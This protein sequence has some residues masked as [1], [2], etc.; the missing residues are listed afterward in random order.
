VALV[1]DVRAAA[2][3]PSRN[4]DGQSAP[5]TVRYLN[6]D[7]EFDS[8]DV[9]RLVGRLR[10]IGL[11]IPVTLEGKVSGTV[12][13][14]VPWNALRT[15][16][17][18]RL[19]GSLTSERFVVNDFAVTAATIRLN[20]R[21]GS[22]FLD[23]FTLSVPKPGAAAGAGAGAVNG[24]AQMQLVPRGQLSASLQVRDL[25]MAAVLRSFDALQPVDGLLSGELV[26]R[27]AVDELRDLAAWR[28]EG[29]I[30][31]R[32]FTL[33]NLPAAAADVRF[34]LEQAVLTAR[35]F[36]LRVGGVTLQSDARLN[37]TGRLAWSLDARASADDAA[38]VFELLKPALHNQ[39]VDDVS[40][41]IRTGPINATAR[42]SGTMSPLTWSIGGHA[43]SSA[44][45]VDAFDGA[46]KQAPI[47]PLV[48]D[49]IDFDYRLDGTML[50]LSQ[51]A[52]DLGGGV[53][54][55]SI[56]VPLRVGQY[57]AQLEWRDVRVTSLLDAPF[58]GNGVANGR[59][60][61][62]AS[63]A[64]IADPA[65]WQLALTTTVDE[66]T[67]QNWSLARL[68]TGE[69]K[70]AD[71]RLTVPGFSALVDNRAI[72]VSLDAQLA[73]PWD[74]SMSF[75]VPELPIAW[76]AKIP[77]I[78]NYIQRP[79][80]YVNVAGRLSGAWKPLRLRGGGRVTGRAVQLDGVTVDALQFGFEMTPEAAKIVDLLAQI[81]GGRVTGAATMA[82]GEKP[83]LATTLGWA[84]VDVAAVTRQLDA[85]PAI[86]S[87]TTTGTLALDIPPGAMGE[88]DKWTATASVQLP[89]F[90][91]YGWQ[92]RHIQ[93]VE[94]RLRAG[95]LK[96]PRLA[97]Q[98]DGQP[99]AASLSLGVSSPW[100]FAGK[101]DAPGLWLERLTSVP[102]LSWLRDRLGGRAQVRGTFEGQVRPV[103]LTA[104]ASVVGEAI[105][106]DQLKIDKLSLRA[107]L[108]PNELR[109]SDVD[110]GLLGGS[111]QGSATIPLTSEGP[112]S[113]QIQWNAVDLGQGLAALGRSMRQLHGVSNGSAAVS[114]PAGRRDD[115]ARWEIDAR[116]GLPDLSAGRLN[117]ASLEAELHQ[118][119]G[120]LNYKAQGR[121]LSG[122]LRLVGSRMQAT[123]E[124]LLEYLGTFQLTLAHASVGAAVQVAQQSYLEPPPVA[125]D[126][127][128]RLASTSTPAGRG[129]QGD[130]TADA[131]QSHGAELAS[132]VQARFGGSA[133]EF[134]VQSVTGRVAGGRLSGAGQWGFDPRQPRAF[135]VSL[136][137]ARLEQL[138]SLET[139]PADAP[140]SGAADIDLRIHP[141][142]TWRIDGAVTSGRGAVYGLPY[143]NARVPLNVRWTPS[144]GRSSLR[145]NSSAVSLSRGRIAGQFTATKSATWTLNGNYRIFRVDIA[146]LEKSLGSQSAHGRGRLSGTL[147]ISGRNVRSVNDVQATLQADLEDTQ[148]NA[149]PLLDKFSR[150]VG[151]FAAASSAFGDGRVEAHLARGVVHVDRLS[152]ASDRMQ[153][154]VTGRIDLVGRLN[155]EATVATGKSINPALAQR[156]LTRLAIVP[157]APASLL[158]QINDI[159]S[160]RVVHLQITGTLTRP[161]IRLRAFATLREE[162]L[163]F[164]LR[165]LGAGAVAP[166]VDR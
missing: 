81:G 54:S 114:I 19:G 160:D 82:L 101:V 33:R 69:V 68:R 89:Q 18:W 86:F 6:T 117:V 55:G 31:L 84:G 99:I 23:E 151:G 148:P 150:Y 14:G 26:A 3:Q 70:I 162:A 48:V 85:R 28:V 83:G 74:V 87:G 17:A 95:Q 65:R 125:G 35:Q 12:H 2:Q 72:D 134:E 43:A 98:L 136:R 127:D 149:V 73:S 126:F 143:S 49:R 64:D 21:D 163:R 131:I 130:I 11:E 32:D 108:R 157:V 139:R 16:R 39:L 78:A 4:S 38:A 102:Q 141:G 52:A 27:A 146:A 153:L 80:G 132:G 92:F 145:T 100:Q 62:A 66:L 103:Q 71:G 165:N 94:L 90:D 63:S 51:L 107:E 1:A 128:L 67:F 123:T 75:S 129:W 116:V 96:A 8:V 154:Y 13:V 144:S 22:L 156:L 164:F 9:G 45:R 47:K 60:G 59:L 37:L 61:F 142:R 119:A 140:V 161:N 53:V 122:D 34:D 106:V 120:V 56:D 137:G 166:S 77:S 30:A 7:W 115:P 58:G 76:L 113:A 44:L 91:V 112:G 158:L 152:L 121:F 155:L 24:T 41:R 5:S 109:V 20:Y 97:A 10:R 135:R 118:H 40:Q 147:Q 159:L 110:A 124:S 111:V 57:A 138:T 36:E 42:L 29:P 133:S 46:G 50:R 25:P 79:S 104:A 105:S 93:P 15:A 88:R